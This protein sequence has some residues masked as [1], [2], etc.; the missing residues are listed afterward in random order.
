MES[1]YMGTWNFG[2]QREIG[3]NTAIDIRYVGT[4][5]VKLGRAID[6]NQVNIAPFMDDFR[7]LQQNGFNFAAQFP[8]LGFD[9]TCGGGFSVDTSVPGCVAPT[10]PWNQLPGFGFLF[11]GFINDFV[12]T[13]QIGDSLAILHFNGLCGAAPCTP[14]LNAGV[15]DMLTNGATSDYHGGSIE[16]RRN[17]SDGLFFQANYTFSK[18]ITDFSADANSSNFEPFLDIA[19]PSRDR[20]RANYDITQAFKANF[21][22]ILPMGDGYGINPENGFLNK[23]VSGWGIT[24]IITMQTGTPISLRT[25]RGSLNRGARCRNRCTADSTL[26]ASQ[27]ADLF[28]I[29]TNPANGEIIFVNPAMINAANNNT[30]VNDE[31]FACVPFG[32]AGLCNPRFGTLGN[33]PLNIIDTPSFFN[34]DFSIKKDTKISEQTSMEFRAEFF[35]FTNHPTFDIDTAEMNINS[36]SFGK[37]NNTLNSSRIVQLSLRFIF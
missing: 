36:T 11:V 31:S 27:V 17:F 35:N 1:P 14:N 24:S 12:R 29:Q 34:W 21:T 23:L 10:G 32:P 19:Q 4:R 28:G 25:G 30:G 6:F 7:I 9:A 2:I 5:G 16:V 37:P 3:W 33:L 20:A 8:A 18:V 22:Y 15:S 13:G 26:T